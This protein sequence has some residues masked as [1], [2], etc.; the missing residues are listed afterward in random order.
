MFDFVIRIK[1]IDKL[2][3]YTNDSVRVK[4]KF[5]WTDQGN[6]KENSRM[7]KEVTWSSTSEGECPF[8]YLVLMR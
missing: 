7:F 2:Q 8:T 3:L 4:V 5:S 6:R 1:T